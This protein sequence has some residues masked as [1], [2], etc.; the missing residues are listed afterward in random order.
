M[1]EFSRFKKPKSRRTDKNA[2]VVDDYLNQIAT[3]VHHAAFMQQY[4]VC[5]TADQHWICMQESTFA[6]LLPGK[7]RVYMGALMWLVGQYWA[8]YP[9]IPNQCSNCKSDNHKD[10]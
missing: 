8:D 10:R 4:T 6:P 7:I 3:A 9:G 2:C 1:L 5:T